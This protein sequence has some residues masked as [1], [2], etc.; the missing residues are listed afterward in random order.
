MGWHP[1][2]IFFL[3]IWLGGLLGFVGVVIASSMDGSGSRSSI[4][5]VLPFLAVFIIF[6]IGIIIIGKMIAGDDKFQ[7]I[8][9]IKATLDAEE[10]VEENED[11]SPISH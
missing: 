6:A 2:V 3:F 1:F 4:L 7:I 9:F 8:R 10:T 5:F 11:H